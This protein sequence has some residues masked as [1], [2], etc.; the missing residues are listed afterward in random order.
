MPDMNPGE[1]IRLNKFI[2]SIEVLIRFD[3]FTIIN[4]EQMSGGQ[5]ISEERNKV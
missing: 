2:I 1:E 3:I 5:G 4:V